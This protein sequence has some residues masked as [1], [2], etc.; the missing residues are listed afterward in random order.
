MAI[1]IFPIKGSLEEVQYSFIS[2]WFCYGGR[3]E[4]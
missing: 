4:F 2:N 3:Q 1:S